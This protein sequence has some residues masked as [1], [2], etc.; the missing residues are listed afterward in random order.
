M[1]KRCYNCMEPIEAGGN[2]PKCGFHSTPLEKEGYLT[3]ET[4]LK[5]RYYIGNIF[6]KTIDSTVYIAYDLELNKKVFV[7]EF[8][9]EHISKL[10]KRHSPIELVQR[11]MSYAKTTA[12][13]S[14]NDILPRTVDTFSEN[15]IGYLVTDYFEGES[16][17][18][19]LGS[20]IKI[21][22]SN[23]LKIAEQLLKG[24]KNM[25]NSGVIFGSL[26]PDTLYILKNGEVRIF[27]LGSSFYDFTDDLDCR[28][29][30]LNP[31]YA[32]PELFGSDTNQVGAYCDVYSVAAILYRLLTNKIP[33][34]SFLRYGGENLVSPKKIDKSIPRNI[35]IALL[36]A[37]NWQ[38]EKRTASPDEFLDELSGK[39]VKR[40][41]SGA[42]IWANILGFF[43]SIY[44][45]PKKAKAQKRLRK[46][47]IVIN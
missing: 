25:H 14:I 30:L 38:T 17:K 4:V 32:A 10:S 20:E 41:R 39:N 24:F 29:E 35:E 42:I 45:N 8:T 34:I 27:G 15:S 22:S 31:S 12:A 47:K 1:E 40:K 9:G 37:L 33:A 21:S 6:S 2:C 19:L 5:G 18:T 43:Q 28:V 36:N 44:D 23:S 13:M 16:L 11:F 46:I 3:E 7:R 26:S